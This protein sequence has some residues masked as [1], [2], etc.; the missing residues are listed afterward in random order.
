MAQID[1]QVTVSENH[2]PDVVPG[3]IR[4][5]L[6][7][8]TDLFDESTISRF[9]DRFT[10]MLESIASDPSARVGDVELLEPAERAVMLEGWND[11]AYELPAGQRLLDGFRRQAAATPDA[12]AVVYEGEALTYAE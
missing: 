6:A 5:H 1:L 7:Y 4:V 8:A 9:G 12:T 10:R 3:W 11:S 2:G